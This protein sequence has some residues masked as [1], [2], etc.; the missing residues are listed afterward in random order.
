MKLNEDQTKLITLL[1]SG[2]EQG[3]IQIS[4]FIL[5]QLEP[6][7]FH[8]F[9]NTSQSRVNDMKTYIK[10]ID[11]IEQL[12]WIEHTG[13]WDPYLIIT[14]NDDTEIETEHGYYLM[15]LDGTGITY[16]YGSEDEDGDDPATGYLDL[17]DI[18]SIKIQY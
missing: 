3:G 14:L 10:V 6:L 16:E 13:D 1:S 15:T 18:K 11:F 4:S 5:N 9:N 7:I 2:A 17:I 12:G 8:D